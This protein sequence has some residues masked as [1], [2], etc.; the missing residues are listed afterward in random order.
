MQYVIPY[1]MPAHMIQK[2]LS[3]N[4]TN[5]SY[6]SENSTPHVAQ[7]V[8]P[9]IR[10]VEEKAVIEST[11]LP[12]ITPRVKRKYNRKAPVRLTVSPEGLHMPQHVSTIPVAV[13]SP[14]I[15][16]LQGNSMLYPPTNTPSAEDIS[17]DSGSDDDDLRS[18]PKYLH[19]ANGML[20]F[21]SNHFHL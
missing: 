19:C 13:C 1:P 17:S 14:D 20:I 3:S 2:S 4:T 8:S 5:T 16:N 12:I 11:T 10:T 9:S 15:H 7:M 18:P 21:I 6:F